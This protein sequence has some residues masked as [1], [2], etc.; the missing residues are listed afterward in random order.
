MRKQSALF[1]SVSVLASYI[2]IPILLYF[3]AS[4]CTSTVY[5]PNNEG[6]WS[7][8][9]WIDSIRGSYATLHLHAHVTRANSGDTG[10]GQMNERSINLYFDRSTS[11]TLLN[12]KDYFGKY[13]SR[14]ST[15]NY[16]YAAG[17]WTIDS[18]FVEF[19]S[20]G[21]WQSQRLKIVGRELPS[22]N[23]DM[24]TLDFTR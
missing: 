7:G 12:G 16:S 6:G 4:S 10:P 13:Y 3:V 19:D 14:Y 8:W 9:V 23:Y 17:T 5:Q 20:S 18:T 24:D 22:Y 15:N 21:V 1:K 11:H 2:L